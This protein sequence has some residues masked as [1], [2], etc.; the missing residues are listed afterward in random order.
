MKEIYKILNQDITVVYESKGV[1]SRAWLL[2]LIKGRVSPMVWEM[3]LIS[4]YEQVKKTHKNI[5]VSDDKGN[6][7]KALCKDDMPWQRFCQ[8]MSVCNPNGFKMKIKVVLDKT[9]FEVEDLTPSRTYGSQYNKSTHHHH[10]TK[11]KA[12]ACQPR[13]NRRGMRKEKFR[14]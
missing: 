10:H 2:Y 8:G 1:L 14:G 7:S 4:Y 5:K 6:L 3:C 12:N 9:T 11:I 13:N